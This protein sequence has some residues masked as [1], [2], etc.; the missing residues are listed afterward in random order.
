MSKQWHLKHRPIDLW[1]DDLTDDERDE[2]PY[3]ACIS[4]ILYSARPP[5]PC[6]PHDLLLTEHAAHQHQ[7]DAGPSQRHRP[8]SSLLSL[9]TPLDASSV[10]TTPSSANMSTL[11]CIPSDAPV[12]AHQYSSALPHDPISIQRDESGK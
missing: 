11:S 9:H 4:C 5:I 8:T 12:L 7:L 10:A 3:N 6:R 1:H 2:L